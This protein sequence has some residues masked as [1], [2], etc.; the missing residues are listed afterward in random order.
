MSD[1]NPYSQPAPARLHHNAA[2]AIV[3]NVFYTLGRVAVIS[4]LAKAWPSDQVGEVIFALSVVTPLSFL[5]NMEIRSVYVTDAAHTIQP[6]LCLHTRLLTNSFFI[7]VLILLSAFFFFHDGIFTATI[8]MMCGLLRIMDSWAD[9]YLGVMQKNEQMRFWSWSQIMKTSLVVIWVCL[10]WV[11]KVSILFLPVGWTVCTAVII[12]FYD[13]PTAARLANLS[14][15]SHRQQ[16]KQLL[17]KA[18]PLGIFVTTTSLNI[19]IAPIIINKHLDKSQV[20][21]YGAMMMFISGMCAIQ[22]GLNHSILPRL[23]GYFQNQRFKFWQLLGIV[24]ALSWAALALVIVSVWWRGEWIL[25]VFFKAEY[26]QQAD[27][28][29][30]IIIGGWLILTSMILGDAII[31]AHRYQSRMIAVILGLLINTLICW[32]GIPSH[33]LYAAAWAGIASPAAV[34]IYCLTVLIITSLDKS[35]IHTRPV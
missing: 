9:I 1:T 31:A 23:A 13:R 21:Y 12:W 2:W 28:F 22:N 29:L 19:S 3:G 11:W 26:A 33:G 4:L 20:A 16:I 15:I 6:G 5:I 7:I 30:L 35:A 14:L 18:L 17:R 32:F 8:I 10:M 27:I 25:K 34:S 24:I